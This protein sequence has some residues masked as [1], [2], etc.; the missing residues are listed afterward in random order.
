MSMLPPEQLTIGHWYNL[1]CQSAFELVAI[2]EVEN[3]LE[4]QYYDG[5][6]A[7]IEVTPFLLA[8]IRRSASP[9]N[10]AGAFDGEQA[11]GTC[12]DGNIQGASKGH[13]DD[14]LLDQLVG[15]SLTNEITAQG[16]AGNLG[17]WNLEWA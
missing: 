5:T 10:L 8:R 17:L 14:N 11:T 1:D 6:I 7:E 4:V 15:G 3:C 16:I 2:D 9:V 13:W 12:F